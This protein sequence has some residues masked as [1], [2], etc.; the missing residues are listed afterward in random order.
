VIAFGK[1]R[2]GP[3]GGS[4]RLRHAPRDQALDPRLERPQPH[5]GRAA[6][7]KPAQFKAKAFVDLLVKFDQ[8]K[9]ALGHGKLLL[10][11]PWFSIEEPMGQSWEGV[12]DGPG[13]ASALRYGPTSLIASTEAN[14]PEGPGPQDL[15]KSE[16]V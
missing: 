3:R 14:Q 4:S 6:R 7:A 10:S 1:V 16:S 12:E 15:I 8:A 9:N 2:E 11:K 13:H 5:D